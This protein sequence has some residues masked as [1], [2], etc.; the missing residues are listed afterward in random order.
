[1]AALLIFDAIQSVAL[2]NMGNPGKSVPWGVDSIHRM[3]FQQDVDSI[4][5][6]LVWSQTPLNF[7]AVAS[8]QLCSVEH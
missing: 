7:W 2:G 8:Y 6:R 4:S 3:H 5:V 1:M